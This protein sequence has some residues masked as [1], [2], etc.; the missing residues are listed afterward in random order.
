VGETK[1]TKKPLTRAFSAGGVVYKKDKGKLLFLIMKPKG[2]DRWQLPKGII[3]K[4]ESSKATAE[5]EVAEEGG[6]KAKLLEKLGT[7]QYFFILKGRRILKTVT[8]FLMEYVSDTQN[9]HDDEADEARFFPHEEAHRKL[10]F[11]DDKEI[12]KK[13]REILN[14]GVQ[15]DLV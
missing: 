3:D 2:T 1:K 9:G 5:R 7:S 6:V 14:R 13:A 11:K 8:Y 15:G 4:D 10:S 12:L